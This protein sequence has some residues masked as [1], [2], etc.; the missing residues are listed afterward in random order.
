VLAQVGA[1]LAPVQR[2]DHQA[3]AWHQGTPELPQ[4]NA[5]T[6]VAEVAKRGAETQHRVEDTATEWER[7]VR[8]AHEERPAGAARGASGRV[9]Q[10]P[11][12]VER[13]HAVAGA[14]ER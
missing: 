11:G 7:G 12:A 1:E 14:R 10:N 2:F 13:D 8:T 4:R 5:I 6:L 3:A 9:E